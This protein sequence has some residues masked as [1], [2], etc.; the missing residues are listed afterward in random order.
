[1]IYE[2][3]NPSDAYTIVSEEFIVAAVA[4]SLL[5]RGSYALEPLDDKAES[6][7]ILFG[8]AR[9]WLKEHGVPDLDAFVTERKEEV[10][11]CLESVLIGDAQERDRMSKVFAAIQNPEDLAR[12]KAV[13]HDQRRSSLNDIGGYAHDLA[14][15]IRERRG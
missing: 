3:I 10:C 13:Y 9:E 12:A 4:V 15:R 11:T 2:I 5:G 8:G 14:K 6:M 1:M 7:P